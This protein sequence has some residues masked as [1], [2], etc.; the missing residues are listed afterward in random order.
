MAIT[1]RA[2]ATYTWGMKD[3]ARLKH[4]DRLD[5]A[6]SG[7]SSSTPIPDPYPHGITENPDTAARH[8]EHHR[9]WHGAVTHAS[10]THW[11]DSRHPVSTAPEDVPS[12]EGTM[13]PLSTTQTLEFGQGINPATGEM[14]SYEEL[15]TDG[16]ILAAPTKD[17]PD[18]PI[19]SIV[20][21]LDNPEHDV[22]G[23]V[24]RLGRYCQ[25]ILM[26]DRYVTVERWEWEEGE[27]K[28][29][30]RIG[31]QFLP[32]ATA[33]EPGLLSEGGRVR[34]WDYEWVC[35]E[36]VAWREVAPEVG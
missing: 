28:R 27:W 15:W 11:L 35:E 4:H 3:Q 7:V 9:S 18:P 26:K 23:V 5:W 13:F 31:D 21:R 25:G 33:F 34:Y 6:F 29:T 14:W 12:D 10:W 2:K 17:E 19:Y 30:V 20:L 24:L 32:C 1:S 8:K 22:R 16:A 36:K